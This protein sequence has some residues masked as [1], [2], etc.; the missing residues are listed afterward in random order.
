M[1]T[2]L[3]RCFLSLSFALAAH[4]AAGAIAQPKTKWKFQTLGAIRAAAV[5]AEE[6]VYFGSADGHLYALDAADGRLR[7]KYR[8]RGAIAASPAV[9]STTTVVSSRDQFIHAVDTETGQARW[10]FE[11]QPPLPSEPDWEYFAA[12]PVI[13]GDRVFAGSSDGHLYVL[14]LADGKLLWSFATRGRIRTAGLV[15]DGVVYQPSNDGFVYVLS[16]A[17]GALQW[18]FMTESATLERGTNFARQGI[19]TPPTLQDGL[20]VFGARDGRTYAVDVATQKEKWSFKYNTTWA[21][22]T[23][24][25]DGTVFVGWSINNIFCALNLA[26]GRERWQFQSGAHV[27]TK[28]LVLGDDVLFGCADGKIY[29]LNKNTGRKRWDYAV[30]REVYSAPIE[31]HGVLIFGSDDGALYALENGTA[32]HKAVYRPDTLEKKLEMFLA[33]EKIAPHLKQRGFAVLRSESALKKFLAERVGDGAPSVVVFAFGG[34]PSEVMGDEP[35]RGLLRQY[36]ET[37]GKAVW[38]GNIPNLFTIDPHGD[39]RRDP[40]IARRLLEVDLV[41]VEDSG[42]YPS[43]T[44]QEGLNWGLPAWMTNTYSSVVR[45]EQV[46]PLSVDEL[47]RVGAWMKKFNPRPGSGFISFR[48]WSFNVPIREEDLA[49]IEHIALHELQ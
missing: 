15:Q 14:N 24:V 13:V 4:A 27:F 46:T 37:G 25:D 32:P 17:N 28:P 3:L 6:R 9:S 21:M 35:E 8:T 2:I 19:Y 26:T 22:A 44:T 39:Y 18:K 47:Q 33:D 23:T 7:W 20:L 43:R 31:H 49:L 38:F 10:R 48:S 36:L 16:A 40:T 1:K 41:R 29:C 34:V 45:A 12:A 30:G 5:V 42:T 11:M